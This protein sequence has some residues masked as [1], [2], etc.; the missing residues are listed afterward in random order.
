MRKVSIRH[1]VTGLALFMSA[2]AAGAHGIAGNRF[3]V[4]TLTF[5]DPSVADEAIVPNFSTLNQPVEGGNATANRFDWAFTRLRAGP[6]TISQPVSPSD[7]LGGC[8]RGRYRDPATQKCRGPAD[9]REI[10]P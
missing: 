5:D 3:F 1:A 8:G 10:K 6:P 2:Q 7:F 4:G 9:V